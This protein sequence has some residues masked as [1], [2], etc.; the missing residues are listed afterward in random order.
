MA[1]KSRRL[2]MAHGASRPDLSRILVPRSED[3]AT[4]NLRDFT[5]HALCYL[6]LSVAVPTLAQNQV[7][8][9]LENASRRMLKNNEKVLKTQ[10][11]LE[12]AKAHLRIARSVYSPQVGITG[13]YERRKNND[14]GLERDYLS[15][16]S[17]SQ[18]IARFGEV[19]GDLDQAQ[20]NVRISEIELERAKQAVIFALR[21]LWHNIALTEEE[22]QQRS[23]VETT[24]Q[25]KL[26]GARRKH[27]EKRI[28][29][30][31]VLNTEMELAEQQLALNELRRRLDI[32]KAEL[33]RL[34]GLDALASVRL[35]GS[36]PDDDL[37]LERAVELG[38]EN[39]LALKELTGA[40]DRQERLVK[41]TLWHR[42][43]ELDASLRYRDAHLFLNQR[44]RTWDTTVVYD[45]AFIKQERDN[46]TPFEDTHDD[47]D[48]WEI[49]MHFNLPLFDGGLTEGYQDAERAEFSRL[50]LE[51]ID[52][53][54]QIRVEVHRAYREVT[55]AKDRME[56]EEKRV[57]IFEQRLRTI[58][59]VIDEGLDLPSYR[60][61]TFDDAFE[62]QAQFTEAQRVFYRV[63]RDHAEAK[64]Q[65]REAMGWRE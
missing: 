27:E 38:L 6:F 16:V 47:R 22:I 1:I 59:R 18:L 24:L 40:I 20:E 54:K 21:R 48:G 28:P 34:T 64:E 61:L 13:L 9:T 65:L 26:K 63:R 62:A 50:K 44:D 15:R 57:Q 45:P 3:S 58:E 49:R 51:L 35:S 55:N 23:T 56:I 2:R 32:D 7:T 42:I 4:R 39:R 52:L 11:I 43:P 10:K 31:S 14:L 41:E 8:L 30:L 25:A 33:I 12:R 36:I 17:L 19:P 37:T 46:V 60:G 5:F 29:I 53:Q